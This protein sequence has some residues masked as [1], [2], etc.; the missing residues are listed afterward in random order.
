[1]HTL[2]IGG[3]LLT[4]HAALA[5]HTLVIE[6]GRIAALSAGRLAPGVGDRVIEANGRWVVPGFIDVHVHEM[7]FAGH[8][9]VGTAF[10]LARHGRDSGGSA[11][12]GAFF[13]ATW[14][15]QLSAYHDDRCPCRH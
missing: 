9:N 1:M 10:V 4:P 2:I 13:R 8:P 5:D 3:T 11:T 7:P 15:Y 12:D 14:R 6:G